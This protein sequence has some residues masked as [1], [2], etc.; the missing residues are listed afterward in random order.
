MLAPLIDAAR[1]RIL[2]SDLTEGEH[3]QKLAGDDERNR[4]DERRSRLRKPECKERIDADD[5]RQVRESEREVAPQ[6]KRSSQLL[7]IAER[8]E[9]LG[10]HSN[11]VSLHASSLSL[12]PT[13]WRS[14]RRYN[15][16][17]V[18]TR[19]PIRRF[20]GSAPLAEN[21]L[22]KFEAIT[23]SRIVEGFGLS[24][25]S[26]VTHMNPLNGVR[27]TGSVGVPTCR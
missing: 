26:P 2:G 20:S 14:P 23:G 19:A 7:A 5:R 21:V 9:L 24:E 16:G 3:D 12:V 4:P 17:G 13:P 22:R 25:A 27:K 8:R 6:S 11:L 10:I 1:D 18:T 15:G